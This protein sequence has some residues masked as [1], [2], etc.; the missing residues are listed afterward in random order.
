MD[1][2]KQFLKLSLLT[3]VV[4]TIHTQFYH[5]ISTEIFIFR[6]HLNKTCSKESAEKYHYIVNLG[7]SSR[8]HMLNISATICKQT[9]EMSKQ[10]FYI[11][12]Q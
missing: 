7:V 6:F 2:K 5:S 3:H 1:F 11:L 4:S 12:I 10:F 8:D 9:A